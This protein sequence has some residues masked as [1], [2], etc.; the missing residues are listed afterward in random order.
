M[1]LY[2]SLRAIAPDPV[3]R[4]VRDIYA[5]NIHLQARADALPPLERDIAPFTVRLMDTADPRD[6]R[7]WLHIQREGFG[8]Q[9]EEADFDRII[10]HHPTYDIRQTYF[11]L[12]RD[13][14]V[15]A[16]SAGVYRGN[17]SIG[18]GHQATVLPHIRGRGLGL[19]LQLYRYHTL[20]AEGL[21]LFGTETT[22]FYRR[23]ILND[24]HIGFRPK[25]RRDPWNQRDNSTSLQ[26]L[27]ANALFESRYLAWRALHG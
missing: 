24:F 12:E 14:P 20:R 7:A 3:R 15:G 27:V 18:I 9:M 5:V 19:Y 13:E 4:F 21:R 23:A 16:A 11:L 26:R 10:L 6:I 17:P 8:Q 25:L 2:S 1:N 22:L